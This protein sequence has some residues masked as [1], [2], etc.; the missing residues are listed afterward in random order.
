MSAPPRPSFEFGAFSLDTGRRRL[1]R[2]GEAVS[3]APKVLDTLVALIENRDRVLSKDELLDLVWGGTNVE[4]GGL[5]RNVSLLRKTLGEKP[6]DH[7]FIVTVPGRGYRFVADVQETTPNEQ[8]PVDVPAR[9]ALDTGGAARP[10]VPRWLALAGLAALVLATTI[11]LLRPGATTGRP[12]ITS[13]AVLPLDNLSGDATQDYFVDGMTEA[14]IGNLAPIGAL[15]VVSRTSVM[16]FK[17]TRTSLAD[18]ARELKVDVVI[19]GSVRRTGNRVSISVQLIDAATDAHLWA[20]EYERQLTDVLKLQGEVARAVADEMRIQVTP[21]ERA[22]LASAGSVDPAAYQEYLLG[23]HYL[24]RL[25]EDDLA[26]AI[27]HFERAIRLDAGYGA[28]YAGLSHAWWWRGVW[29]AKTFK[30]IEPPSRSAARRALAL[31]PRLAEAHVSIGRLKFGHDWDWAGAEQ[32]FRHALDIDPNNLDAHFFSAMLFMALG[33]FSES[34]DH[35]ERAARRDPLSSTVQSAFG[36]V[37][38]RA[39]KFDEALPH[40]NQAIALEPRGSDSYGRLGDVYEALGRYDEALAVYEKVNALRGDP[41]RGPDI[42]IVFARMGKRKEANQLLATL[43]TTSP[44]VRLAQAYAVLGND[45][46]AFRLLFRL[47][48]ER[49]ALNYVKTE[50]RLDSLHADPRWR[51]LLRRMNLPIDGE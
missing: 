4:E 33:R 1:L 38:Y 49:N 51:E 13:L 47:A 41:G 43:R 29:G 12:P 35:I 46:E 9:R 30:E 45:D 22:R 44:L 6:D 15:R 19:E 31:D 2:H 39:R 28:A 50:P 27:D 34:I 5:T 11:Y 48:D 7:Q 8:A 18:I 3:L 10:R 14:L 36:R 26:T 17:G 40:L 20:R 42:A 16:R 32:D 23:Q 25:T 21:G 37:L 24:W